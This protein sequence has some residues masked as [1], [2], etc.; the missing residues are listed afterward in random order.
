MNTKEYDITSEEEKRERIKTTMDDITSRETK[1][2]RKI[3]EY[4][5]ENIS[6]W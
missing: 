1:R 4:N 2:K 6:R 3:K 5:R